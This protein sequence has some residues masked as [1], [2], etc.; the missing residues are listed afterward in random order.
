M[1]LFTASKQ[2]ST[3]PADQRFTTLQGLHEAVSGY[4]ADAREATRP[5]ADLH[6]SADGADVV[7]NGKANLPARFTHWAFGQLCARVQAPA[8]YLRALPPTLA[9]ENLNHGIATMGADGDDPDAKLLLHR[10]GSLLVR[11]FT[12]PRYTRIWNSDITSRLLA[13]GGPWQPAPAACDGSRGLY[14]SDH[15]MFAFM[16]DND[17]RIFEEDHGGLARGFF[18][19][20]SEVGAAAFSITTFLY[21]YVCGNHIVWGAKGVK[22][23]R[24]RHTGAADARAFGELEGELRQY[25]DASESDERGRIL[26][27]R[28]FRLGTDKDTVLDSIFKLRVAALSRQR[29]SASYDLA[30]EHET[31]DGDPTTA[32]GMANGITRLSQTLPYADERVSLDRAAGKVLEMAF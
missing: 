31:T 22:E 13:L 14:A 5:Y 24:L 27:A 32:W 25:S 18:V 19:S 7:V 21:R 8:S 30:V 29:I 11:A 2:W 6:M 23:L 12:S 9:A 4:R 20:N 3:R 26:S 10:N 16:V 15:D 28:R 1:E 17:R